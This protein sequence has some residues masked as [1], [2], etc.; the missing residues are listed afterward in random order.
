V[1]GVSVQVSGRSKHKHKITVY[2]THEELLNLDTTLLEL[3]RRTGQQVDR[4]RYIREAVF[5]S[6]LAKVVARIRE[7]G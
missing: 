3:R 4:G 6:S 1:R 2:L 7:V 5:T